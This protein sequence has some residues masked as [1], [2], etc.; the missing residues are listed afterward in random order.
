MDSS[1]NGTSRNISDEANIEIQR[2]NF[3]A[4]VSHD[5]KNPTIAQIR[6]LELFLKGSFGTLQ[7]N[8]KEIIQM[9]L[10]SCK[11]MNAMLCSLLAT[12]RCEKGTVKLANDEISIPELATEC[13]DE[14]IYLAK[15]KGISISITNRTTNEF[16]FGDRIQLKRVIMNLI[17][18]GIKYAYNNTKLDINVYNKD[19]YTCFE[20]QNHSP[21]ITPEKQKKIFAKYVTYSQSN[22]VIGIGL[23]L[24]TS[25]KIIEAHG[26][27]I[28][29]KSYTDNITK[30]GF[31]IPNDYPPQG[32]ERTVTF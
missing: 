11:Y 9:V 3:V 7:P 8:Q 4:S 24:Y 16:V 21:Y 5:L 14:M 23:G 28:F 10:D 27:E 22:N 20:F 32:V 29:V 1:V 19:D 6:A 12:Y 30:F 25:K 15:D 26:G 2:E 18:N 31:K 13:V 17:T